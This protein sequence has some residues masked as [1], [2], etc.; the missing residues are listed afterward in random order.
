LETTV[1]AS[2]FGDPRGHH[3]AEPSV[4]D[5][6]DDDHQLVHVFHAHQD[7]AAQWPQPDPAEAGP[8]GTTLSTPRSAGSAPI[9]T[10]WVRRWGISSGP[11]ATA[12]SQNR[13]DCPITAAAGHRVYAARISPRGPASASNT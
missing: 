9:L 12:S 3:R 1:K 4:P 5:A 6:S 7:Q 8:R 13:W 10:A 2:L 11:N